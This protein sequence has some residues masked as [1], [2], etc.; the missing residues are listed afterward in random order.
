MNPPVTPPNN[1]LTD[2]LNTQTGRF[3]DDLQLLNDSRDAREI[4]CFSDAFALPAAD[5]FA[6]LPSLLE[7]IL[8]AR[9]TM[10][11]SLADI[12]WIAFESFVNDLDA[13]MGIARQC[14]ANS[15]TIFANSFSNIYIQYQNSI[16]F[17]YSQFP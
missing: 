14:I 10:W 12:D 6:I 7:A 9:R 13:A 5:L 8:E 17:C 11:R 3:V 15:E 2:C 4:D 1:L 16:N